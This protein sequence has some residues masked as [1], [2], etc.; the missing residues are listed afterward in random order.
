MRHCLFF[1]CLTLGVFS[2]LGCE[3]QA[4]TQPTQVT[5]ESP[6]LGVWVMQSPNHV[7]SGQATNIR[8]EFKP[9]G[10]GVYEYTPAGATDP[11][12]HGLTYN[13][14]GDILSIDSD[15][16]APDAPRLTGKIAFDPE[17]STLQITTHTGEQWVLLRDD[18][19]SPAEEPAADSPPQDAAAADASSTDP[20]AAAPADPMVPRVQQLVEACNRYVLLTGTPPEL[21]ID[22]VLE[23]LIQ[24]EHLIASGDASDLPARYG[25][26]TEQG[27]ADWLESNGAFTFFFSYAGTDQASSVVVTT[28]PS[29][30]DSKVVIGMADGS[31]HHKPAIETAQLLQFQL[32]ELPSRWPSKILPAGAFAGVETH[33]D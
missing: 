2:V 7:I 27:R 32:G 6:M 5:Y 17:N 30:A 29:N 9:Q 22:L 16:N 15:S 28:L 23:G 18:P 11:Q 8:F 31:V 25:R 21:A 20:Q 10:A 33:T 1:S 24:P 4:Q 26:M 19:S 3:E 13:L 14:V 12:R